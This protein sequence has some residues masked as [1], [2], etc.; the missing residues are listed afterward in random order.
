VT[1]ELE[2][3]AERDLLSSQQSPVDFGQ[4]PCEKLS[5][6][7]QALALA[8]RLSARYRCLLK[9]QLS[10]A[11]AEQIDWMGRRKNTT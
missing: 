3:E 7:P 1:I 4:P 10:I 2:M 5:H 6:T 11:T 9:A 8:W